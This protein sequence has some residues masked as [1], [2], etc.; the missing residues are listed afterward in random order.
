MQKEA[1]IIIKQNTFIILFV[2]SEIMF[3]FNLMYI[4][5]QLNASLII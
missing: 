3:P 4:F 2:F 5:K 1:S